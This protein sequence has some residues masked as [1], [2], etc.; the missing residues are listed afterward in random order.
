DLNRLFEQSDR[1]NP[2]IDSCYVVGMKIKT[3]RDHKKYTPP[4]QEREPI[5][6]DETQAMLWAAKKKKKP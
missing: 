2:S 4:K 1:M 6:F 3:K 5:P